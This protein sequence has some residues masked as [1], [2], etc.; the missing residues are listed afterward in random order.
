MYFEENRHN[1]AQNQ[2]EKQNFPQLYTTCINGLA[3]F[4]E[5]QKSSFLLFYYLGNIFSMSAIT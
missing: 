4:T 2:R 3:I 5:E 1:N